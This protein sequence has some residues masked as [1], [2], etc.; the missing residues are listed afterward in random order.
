[1][2]FFFQVVGYK[3]IRLYC[4]DQTAYLYPHD[5]VLLGNT[6]QVDVEGDTSDFPEFKKAVYEDLIIGPGECVYIPPKCWHYIRS[7]SVSFSVSFW[8]TWTSYYYVL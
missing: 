5:D 6:S 2:F 4:E 7:L 3:Y 1:M 8:W